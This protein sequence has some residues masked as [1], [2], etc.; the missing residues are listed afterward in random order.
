MTATRKLVDKMLIRPAAPFTRF[1]SFVS[2]FL[3]IIDHRPIC[4]ADTDDV[5]IVCRF[6]ATRAVIVPDPSWPFVTPALGPTDVNCRL[7]KM[8]FVRY[9]YHRRNR[10]HF[11]T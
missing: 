6:R 11:A 10:S 3:F 5:D 9:Q 2:Q 7:T 4:E 1:G 8:M